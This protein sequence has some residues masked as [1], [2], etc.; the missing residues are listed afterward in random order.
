MMKHKSSK[1]E[2]AVYYAQLSDLSKAKNIEITDHAVFHRILQVLRLEIND[3][4]ILFDQTMHASCT[5][6]SVSKKS[7][8]LSVNNWTK[9]K[10]IEPTITFLLP[11]L[12]RDALET[13]IYSLVELGINTI[14][15]IITG[16]TQSKWYGSHEHDRLFKIMIAAAEQ[17]KN[18]AG[19][20]L[21]APIPL[22]ESMNTYAADSYQ[23]IYADPQGL[24]LQKTLEQIKKEQHV[25]LMTGPEGDLLDH[26]KRL[27][28][29]NH[30]I[31][32]KLTP[33]MLRSSQAIA[34][35]SGIMRSFL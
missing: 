11:L 33:T 21:Y 8:M 4:I 31:F 17:S 34:L 5:I 9:N 16:K 23:K 27:L 13:A 35:L 18:F 3:S 19:A 24:P 22:I 32:C 15:L 12:K 7:L 1:H 14:Q 26:E 6:E 20:N 29:D 2:F 25:V 28:V 10:V 30:F